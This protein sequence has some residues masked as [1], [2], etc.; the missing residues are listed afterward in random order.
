MLEFLETMGFAISF[1]TWQPRYNTI[2]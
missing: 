1:A 2:K